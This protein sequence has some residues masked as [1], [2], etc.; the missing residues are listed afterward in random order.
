M[1]VSISPSLGSSDL[2]LRNN[3][4]IPHIVFIPDSQHR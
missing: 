2:S 1:A 4:T 3:P